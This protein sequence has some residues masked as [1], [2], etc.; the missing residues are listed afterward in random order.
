MGKGLIAG[1][2]VLSGL[3]VGVAAALKPQVGLGFVV[4]LGLLGCWRA[5]G[6]SVGVVALMGAVGVGRL[7]VAGV[8]WWGPFQANLARFSE[9]GA[10]GDARPG[11]PFRYQM[12]DLRPVLYVVFS[13]PRWVAAAAWGLV[14]AAA[15]VA[16]WRLRAIGLRRHAL[17]AAGGVAVLTLMPTYHRFYDA[18]VLL[19]AA[20]WV[21]GRLTKNRSEAVGWV[22]AAALAPFLVPGSAALA[23][24]V[25]RGTIPDSIA[26]TWLWTHVMM[27]HQSWCLVI[28][29]GCLLVALFREPRTG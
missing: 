18:A 19:V 16:I 3:L 8:E 26:G 9:P 21:V 5:L 17:L 6:W 25:Q 24:L 13:E 7:W 22:A 15:G 11:G 10:I 12:I 1:A 23:T 4:L 29:L 28:L 14:L 2:Q 27:Q 20:V